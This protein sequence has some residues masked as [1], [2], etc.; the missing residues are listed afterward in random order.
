MMMVMVMMVMVL[1]VM[2][3]FM[4]MMLLVRARLDSISRARARLD[5][6]ASLS[7]PRGRTRTW[8]DALLTRIYAHRYST[9]PEYDD[10]NDYSDNDS[11]D[12]VQV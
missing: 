12:D 11:D 1:M 7:V 3:M 5:S 10:R 8:S 9:P 6:V 2:R 4:M